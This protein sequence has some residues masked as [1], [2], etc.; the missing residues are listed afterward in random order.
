[1]KAGNIAAGLLLM[2]A[3]ALWGCSSSSRSGDG[4]GGA[5]TGTMRSGDST[6]TPSSKSRPLG[7]PDPEYPDRPI[8]D[9]VK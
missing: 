6:D 7:S 4:S 9:G 5:A 8:V 2:G 3:V 1:M